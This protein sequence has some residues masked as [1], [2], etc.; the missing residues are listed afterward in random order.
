[1][2]FDR[3]VFVNCP[4]DD[5]YYPLLRPLLFTIIVLGFK[6]RIA[7]EKLD[8]GE[9]R[10]QKVMSLIRESKYAVHD[11]SRIEAKSAGEIFRFNMPFELGLDIG[12]KKYGSRRFAEKKCLI[13]EVERYRYQSAISDLSN[14]DIYAHHN[15]PAE[16][17][18]AVRNWLVSEAGVKAPGP[19]KLWAQ[20]NEFMAY[21]FD[22]LT[23][24]GWSKSDI[25]SLAINELIVYM[26]EW[27]SH[28]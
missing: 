12:C 13:L 5:E 18:K 6:P 20:F 28:A 27:C 8:S 11:L 15:V 25:K 24:E 22:E 17:V 21:N 1:M 14:S 26:Q 4:F 10:I 7:L 3:N 19:S 2:A 9:P 16:V 23:R